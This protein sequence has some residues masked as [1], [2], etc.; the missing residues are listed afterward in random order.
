[1]LGK[2]MSRR[3]FLTISAMTAMFMA[4]DKKKLSALAEKISPKKDFPTVV[5]GA[6]LGGLCAAAYL[7][8]EGFPVTV[9]E[10]HLIPGGYATS[11]SRGAGDKYTFEVSL[12]GTAL[13]NTPTAR[14]LDDLG[15]LKKLN[16]VLAPECYRFKTDKIDIS[17]PQKDPEAYIQLLSM[18]F[19]KEAKGIR[20][21]MDV[22]IGVSEDADRLSKNKGKFVKLLFPVQYKHMWGVRNKT[23]KGLLDEH[24][25]DPELK[26]ALASLWGYYGLP[27]SKLSAFYYT[28]ATGEYFKH[29]SYYIKERSQNLSDALAEL[30]IKGGGK[31]LY[32][33]EA[34]KILV[35]DNTVSGVEV[36]GGKNIPARIVVSNASAPD[37]L[38]KMLPSNA[39][40]EDYTKKIKGYRPSL[41][42]FIVWLGLNRELSGAIKSY[43]THISNGNPEDEYQACLKGDIE[44]SP[45]AVTIYDNLFKGYSKPG[46]STISIVA[47]C[48]YDFW[49]RFESDY[50]EGKKDE[51]YKE[52]D[53][54]T[55]TLIKRAEHMLIPGLSLM[56]D[57]VESATPLTNWSFTRNYQ[58]AIYGYDETVDNSFM[59]RIENHTPVKGLYL[60][61]AWGNP[62]GGYS[63][64]ING[65]YNTFVRII[66]D[67]TQ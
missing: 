43:T 7:V 14:I 63:G 27:P 40:P 56:I 10:Q 20:S 48:G 41:S 37:T 45:F 39:L 64:V 46:C 11:F 60:A 24:I 53:R 34:K 30:I 4:M 33:T 42:T 9:V 3:T 55:Q 23:L 17:V 66:E 61:S 58:G 65:G 32:G 52:K 26:N 29:G 12:H 25:K 5:I 19:P 8:K 2:K 31:I 54:W 59:N 1:M 15:I 44:N 18:R 6:G 21:F 49:G 67:L 38:F 57:V 51:Y 36:S 13:H 50:K 47:L 28:V 62:G 22:M 16:L 35:K